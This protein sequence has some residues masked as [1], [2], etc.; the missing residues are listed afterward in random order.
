M[1]G[2]DRHFRM[3]AGTGTV[4]ELHEKGLGIG[5]L[6]ATQGDAE[7]AHLGRTESNHVG[8]AE[9]GVHQG[10]NLE[11]T[12]GDA[13]PKR[14][15]AHP[16]G[17][18]VQG[19]AHDLADAWGL[20]LP[21][22]DEDRLP[23]VVCVVPNVREG[24]FNQTRIGLTCGHG[25]TDQECPAL[26]C[27]EEAPRHVD[28]HQRLGCRAQQHRVGQNGDGPAGQR[29]RDGDGLVLPRHQLEQ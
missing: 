13:V 16:L 1:Q 8:R 29:R 2:E 26:R 14:L 18:V 19:V 24:R 15:H 5:T 20:V 10:G 25:E 22:R 17:A 12:I 23:N 9:P 11:V 27:A 21:K 7:G 4:R 3:R 6:Q 28:R